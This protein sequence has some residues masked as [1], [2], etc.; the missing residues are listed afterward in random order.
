[1]L[2]KIEAK[3]HEVSGLVFYGSA[4][5]IANN[6]LWQYTVFW[7]DRT[8]RNQNNTGF[9]DYYSVAIVHENFVPDEMIY[10]MISKMEELP[11][12]RLSTEDIRFDYSA[13]PGTNAV[14]EIATLTFCCSRKRV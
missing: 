10:L 7:R 3:L 12:V 2:Q 13:K 9:T 14:V 8:T 4:D 6:V 5:D 11:G 1:M